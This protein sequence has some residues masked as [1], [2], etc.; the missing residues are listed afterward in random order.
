MLYN[1]K[2][3]K[4][5]I[6]VLLALCGGSLFAQEASPSMSAP[7][8]EVGAC[9]MFEPELFSALAPSQSQCERASLIFNEAQDGL[10]QLHN[11][12]VPIQEKVINLLRSGQVPKDR[13]S[14]MRKVS[15]LQNKVWDL[16]ERIQTL[17]SERRR[18]VIGVFDQRQ[19]MLLDQ[20][21]AMTPAVKLYGQASGFLIEGYQTMY[22]QPSVWMQSVQQPR[23]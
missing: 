20:L 11:E 9:W 21:Q 15:D 18:K 12:V 22:P 5:L 4:N 17:M 1:S 10:N 6:L 7:T 13:L 14:A 2:S 16:E 23:P 19:R 8:V 3:M